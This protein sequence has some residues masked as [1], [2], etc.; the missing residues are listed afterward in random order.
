MLSLFEIGLK[1]DF[2]VA[3]LGKEK[4]IRYKVNVTEEMINEEEDRLRMRHGKMNEPET[5]TGDDNVLNVSFIES[6]AD[7]N[8]VEGG[9]KKDNSL[10]VKY[11]NA[12]FRPTLNGKKKDDSLVIQINTAFDEKERVDPRRPRFRQ[13]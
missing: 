10:L 5:V 13:A 1:P 6:D 2:K 11:F 3:D 12:G 8:E 9:V 7:G 4:L